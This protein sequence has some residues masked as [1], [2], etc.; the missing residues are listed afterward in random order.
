MLVKGHEE[1]VNALAWSPDCNTLASG[2]SDGVV[3]VWRADS[4]QELHSLQADAGKVYSL[5]WHP[6]GTRLATAHEDPPK[7]RFSYLQTGVR[8]WDTA[9]G[10]ELLTLHATENT[11]AVA[12]SSDGR[13]LLAADAEGTI[14]MWDASKGY[15]TDDSGPR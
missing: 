11:M 15:T 3:K 13:R 6:D 9:S 10:T 7:P 4:G 2:S 5:A 14:R 8:I 12:W 1:K